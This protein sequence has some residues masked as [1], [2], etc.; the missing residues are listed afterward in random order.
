MRMK[1]IT[2]L[3]LT[4]LATILPIAVTV[5]VLY[6][7]GTT[8]ESILGPVLERAIPKR[9]YRPGFGVVAGVGV[10]FVVGVLMK[11][12]LFRSLVALGERI[13]GRIPLVKTLYCALRDLMDFF[14]EE[15]PR[16][17]PVTVQLGDTGMRL[18]GFVTRENLT[19]TP[20]GVEDQDTVAVFLPMSYQ[21]GGFTIMV[22]RSAVRKID[23]SVEQ[24]MRFAVTAGIATTAGA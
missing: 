2:K 18:I 6:W 7:L 1:S 9:Y 10:V 22:P 17:T 15:R 24:A 19:N 5:Y 23:M 11:A 16:M 20:L 21:M 3:F 13:L 12:Y 8:A 14:A 4:G